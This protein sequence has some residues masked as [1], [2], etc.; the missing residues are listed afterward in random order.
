LEILRL[1]SW[2]GKGGVGFLFKQ[3]QPTITNSSRARTKLGR[4]SETYGAFQL[5]VCYPV[6]HTIRKSSL[7]DDMGRV[8]ATQAPNRWA[9]FV[10]FSGEWELLI[11]MTSPIYTVNSAHCCWRVSGGKQELDGTTRLPDP[12]TLAHELQSKVMSAAQYVRIELSK[13]KLN[14]PTSS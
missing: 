8:W 12:E 2:R 4:R 13:R 1:L 6:R 3:P 5:K 9:Y 10:N 7:S 11:T 14:I